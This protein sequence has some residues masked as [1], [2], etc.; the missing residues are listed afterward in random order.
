MSNTLENFCLNKGESI[1][2]DLKHE[3]N[4]VKE[5]HYVDVYH[6]IVYV[7]SLNSIY[8]SVYHF[9]LKVGEILLT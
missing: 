9:S 8:L 7:I 5:F 6:I 2:E 3:P 1:P 4:L